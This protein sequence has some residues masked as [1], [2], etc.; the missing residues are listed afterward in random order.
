MADPAAGMITLLLIEMKSSSNQPVLSDLGEALTHYTTLLHQAIRACGGTI[1]KSDSDSVYAAFP[2]AP[3]ALSAALA[4]YWTLS[5]N[6]WP[7]MS[8]PEVRMALHTGPTGRYSATYMGATFNHAVSLLAACHN[9]QILLSRVT[10]DLIGG[11]IPPGT[12]LRDLGEHRL[13]DLTRPEHIFQLVTRHRP[14]SLPLSINLT[15][16]PVNLPMLPTPLIGRDREVA[17]IR[18]ML[19]H[20]DVSLLTLLGSSGT[21]KTRLSLQVAVEIAGEF[22]DGVYFVPLAP[23]GSPLLVASAIAQALGI[24][25]VGDQPL[26]ETLHAYLADR[27]TLLILDNFEQLLN[28]APLVGGL[29]AAAPRLKVL[30]TSQLRLELAGELAFPVP[31]LALPD[32]AHLPSLALLMQY[33]SIA[34]FY[35]RAQVVQPD[36]TLTPENAVTVAELCVCLGGVPLAIELVA[37]YG[38]RFAPDEMLAQIRERLAGAAKRI[39]GELTHKQMLHE[40]LG[41]N[42]AL[43]D[44]DEQALLA[45]MG[46]FEGGCTLEAAAVVCNPQ[47]DLAIDI[48][49]GVALLLHKNLLVQE[50]WSGDEPRYMMLD[51]IHQFAR[52]RLAERGEADALHRWHA[53]HFL[54]LAE[55]GEAGLT[56]PQQEVWLKR[57]EEDLHNLRAALEWSIEPSELETAVRLSGSLWR[58][59]YIRGYLSEGRRWLT[60]A[61]VDSAPVP[62]PL[63][64]KALTGASVLSFLQGDY[65]Q[66]RRF[67][68]ENLALF[69]ALGDKRGIANTLSNLGAMANEQEDYARAKQLL[70]ES[71]DLRREIG[72]TWGIAVAL[73]NLAMAV[74]G[75]GDYAQAAALYAESLARF[76]ELSDKSSIATLTAN[77]G[78][79]TLAQGYV[80]RA[81]Q[82]FKESLGLSQELGYK[83]GIASSL[84]GCAQLAA[85]ERRP[86]QAARLVGVVERIYEQSDIRPPPIERARHTR[87]VDAIRAQIND[88]AFTAALAEGQAMSVEQAIS[89]ILG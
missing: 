51:M 56:G 38:D 59:W 21:G 1:F 23:V 52:R 11:H 84:E 70:T 74:E 14:A 5:I 20:P 53:A 50:E 46:I 7:D 36:F 65:A 72:D 17:E 26:V 78:W 48:L 8:P 87:T 58:F 54:A 71:L 2:T 31:P 55:Q 76:Q 44:A 83:E 33:P 81:A 40:V 68:E 67:A 29:L 77:L 22:D 4:A 3:A 13:R 28:S 82:F 16:F 6:P 64:T 34:L 45:R 75:E 47:G 43:L 79:M 41:W 42:Y 10:Y 88:A 35:E 63:R 27:Q 9:G 86:V 57:L 80:E 60:A 25:E 32:P 30:V 24:K 69:R 85:V 62:A 37:A 15:H 49:R 66:A 73:N 12:E 89:F 39:G 18:G 61:L 19:R